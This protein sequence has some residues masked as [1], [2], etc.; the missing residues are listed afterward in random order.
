MMHDFVDDLN[1]YPF[2]EAISAKTLWEAPQKLV[3][4][5]RSR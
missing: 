3:V 2:V 4:E 5:Y 1:C